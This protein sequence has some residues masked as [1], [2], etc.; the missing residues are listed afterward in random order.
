[1]SVTVTQ[2]IMDGSSKPWVGPLRKIRHRSLRVLTS[3]MS[4]AKTLRGLSRHITPVSP[5]TSISPVHVDA[6][7][8][9]HSGLP[10]PSPTS[11]YVPF[12]STGEESVRWLCDE[13]PSPSP[14]APPRISGFSRASRP[15]VRR[16]HVTAPVL[17]RSASSALHPSLHRRPGNGTPRRPTP[18]A[19]RRKRDDQEIQWLTTVHRSLIRNLVLL[20]PRT[21]GNGG[22]CHAARGKQWLE[23]A[24][25][26][27]ALRLG[28]QLVE[29]G[30]WTI[31]QFLLPVRPNL[32]S[33]RTKPTGGIV[34]AQA[35]DPEPLM[36]DVELDEDDMFIHPTAR[37]RRRS[38]STSTEP[39]T[40]H[41]LAMDVRERSVPVGQ[42]AARMLLRHRDRSTARP[43]LRGAWALV[44]R[45][46]PPNSPLSHS[47]TFTTCT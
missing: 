31:P 4:P 6:T 13:P 36:V 1:M 33:K 14:S 7:L 43:R 22:V 40:F 12:P 8:T 18:K 20:R 47:T 11:S 34:G 44:K 9:D 3:T 38:N 42:L 17:L 15:T 32:R 41:E 46:L 21:T 35:Q 10:S 23:D 26:E 29:R 19:K 28:V 27:L 2:A 25:H 16:G 37:I 30:H 5:T 45:P 24:D 39:T